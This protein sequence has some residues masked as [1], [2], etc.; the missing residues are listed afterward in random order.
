MRTPYLGLCGAFGAGTRRWRSRV[1]SPPASAPSMTMWPSSPG[2]TCCPCRRPRLPPVTAAAADAGRG[3]TDPGPADCRGRAAARPHDR[4]QRR[5]A[6]PDRDL[7]PKGRARGG[8][9]CANALA[10]ARGARPRPRINP[11]GQRFRLVPAFGVAGLP[12]HLFGVRPADPRDNCGTGSLSASCGDKA[13]A[14]RWRRGLAPRGMSAAPC[15]PA[16][17]A[18]PA[19]C[20]TT[21]PESISAACWSP[22]AWHSPTR[23]RATTISARRTRRAQSRRGLWAF[24]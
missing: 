19:S 3:R 9:A 6:D 17:A 16:S 2:S 13:P 7:A 11:A 12:V 18:I 14:R 21:A 4:R 5:A 15:P 1:A 23:P 8:R 22:K 24:R 20:A 10:R